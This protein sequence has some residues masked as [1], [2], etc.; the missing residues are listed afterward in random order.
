MYGLTQRVNPSGF[1]SLG[2]RATEDGLYV[3]SFQIRVFRLIR[4]QKISPLY[5]N[6]G[7][8]VKLFLHSFIPVSLPTSNPAVS[9]L[10]RV[11]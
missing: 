2:S 8:A 10:N 9:F 4:G 1:S 7:F 5:P 3:S 6:P 11:D